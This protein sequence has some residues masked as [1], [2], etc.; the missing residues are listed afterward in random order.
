MFCL[1]KNF[2][3]YYHFDFGDQFHYLYGVNHL[4]GQEIVSMNGT[5]KATRASFMFLQ[6]SARIHKISKRNF[7]HPKVSLTICNACTA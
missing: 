5:G 7:D 2:Y 3:G 1:F 4:L 6:F